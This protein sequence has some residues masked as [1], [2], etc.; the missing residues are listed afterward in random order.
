MFTLLKSVPGRDTG[1]ELRHRKIV[2]RKS[3]TWLI[4]ILYS[5]LDWRVKVPDEQQS[6]M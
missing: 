2:A 4:R 5:Y 3:L 1:I 6:Q